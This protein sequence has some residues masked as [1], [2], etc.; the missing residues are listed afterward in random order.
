MNGMLGSP[1]PEITNYRPTIAGLKH[2]CAA[3]SPPAG[4]YV[5]STSHAH[6][7]RRCRSSGKWLTIVKC[8]RP[9]G[10]L[11]HDQTTKHR[12]RT[13][14]F[15]CL[16][17]GTSDIGRFTRIGRSY[18]TRH[19]LLSDSANSTVLRA[20]VLTQYRRVTDRRT[21]GQM[22]GIAVAS[23]A[24]AMRTLRRAITTY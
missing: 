18:K 13:S 14:E 24:L 23:T 8:G 20:V 21:D 16:N 6:P 17:I 22:D 10:L 7:N 11:K 2:K 15:F 1:V 12:N 19:I 4:D 5:I 9:P 3:P